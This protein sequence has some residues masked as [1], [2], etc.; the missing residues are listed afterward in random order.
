MLEGV[1]KGKVIKLCQLFYSTLIEG[2]L[3]KVLDFLSCRNPFA[4]PSAF[5][6]GFETSL[7]E[8]IAFPESKDVE[9]DFDFVYI[10]D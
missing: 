5:S 7:K 6:V 8:R 2:K 10:F 3:S 4:V 1:V 9:F